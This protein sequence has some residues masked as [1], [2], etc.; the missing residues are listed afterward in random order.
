[1]STPL[2][3]VEGSGVDCVKINKQT[4]NIPGSLPCPSK[5]EKEKAVHG[6]QLP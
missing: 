2:T 1:M 4:K 3:I 6:Q 5:K